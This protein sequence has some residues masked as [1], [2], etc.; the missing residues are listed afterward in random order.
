MLLIVSFTNSLEE[1]LHRQEDDTGCLDCSSDRVRFATPCS[2]ICEHRSV[3]A[4]QHAVQQGPCGSFVD[5]SLCSI[6]IK[7][8]IKAESL[9]F[10]SSAIRSGKL[11]AALDCMVLRWVE[12]TTII[13]LLCPSSCKWIALTGICRP[14]P[15]TRAECPL[16]STRAPE[17]LQESHHRGRGDRLAHASIAQLLGPVTVSQTAINIAW[18]GHTVNGRTLIATLIEEAPS[19]AAMIACEGYASGKG[20]G[21]S[22]AKPKNCSEKKRPGH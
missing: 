1:L 7:H 4:I 21:S 13:S 8:T 10:R 20:R 11:G 19:E 22:D 18:T 16:I 3:V 14:P 2:S 15:S 5:I 17:L 12:D 9:I 6:L